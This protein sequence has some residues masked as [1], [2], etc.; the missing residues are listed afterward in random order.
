[1]YQAKWRL[2]ILGDRVV[3]TLQ[4][5]S[6]GQRA[7]LLA[8]APKRRLF[9]TLSIKKRHMKTHGNV[10]IAVYMDIR[11]LNARGMHNQL[12]SHCQSVDEAGEGMVYSSGP[13]RARRA[14]H[15]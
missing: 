2:Y 10:G 7:N 8:A 6:A 15:V 13:G 9:R 11:G 14:P 3:P 12:A 1:V 4:F 5:R